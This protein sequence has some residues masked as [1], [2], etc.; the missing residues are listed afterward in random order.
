MYKLEFVLENKMH[1]ILLDF[2]IQTNYLYILVRKP[3][4]RGCVLVV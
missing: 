2:A 1:K 3:K 4:P